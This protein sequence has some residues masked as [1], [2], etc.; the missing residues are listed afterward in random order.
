VFSSR[1]YSLKLLGAAAIVAALSAYAGWRGASINPPLWRCLAQPERWDGA[2]LRAP[3]I[4]DAGQAGTFVLRQQGSLQIRVRGA[5]PAEGAH[6]VVSGIFHRHGP[7]IE[8]QSVRAVPPHARLRWI[9]EAASCL[10]L[11]LLLVNFAR[12]FS[13]RMGAVRLEAR[14]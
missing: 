12:H 10:V 14:D 7:E 4:V 1:L 3:G 13:T 11:A 9:S 2:L 5:A 8:M 6:V